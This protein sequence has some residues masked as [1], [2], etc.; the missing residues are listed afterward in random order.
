MR[1]THRRHAAITGS[2]IRHAGLLCTEA[3]PDARRLSCVEDTIRIEVPEAEFRIRLTRPT[4]ATTRL[5]FQA[6]FRE[7]EPAGGT[8]WSSWEVDVTAPATSPEVGHA[9]AAEVTHSRHTF[10]TALA[11]AQ[12]GAEAA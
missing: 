2:A 3:V 11:D 9:L 12:H 6:V 1:T 4:P 7:D 5:C 10:A 8:W